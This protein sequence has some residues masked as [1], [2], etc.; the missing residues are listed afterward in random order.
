ME[1]KTFEILSELPSVT[2]AKP[3]EYIAAINSTVKVVFLQILR[4]WASHSH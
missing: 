2:K 4:K 1:V 3:P